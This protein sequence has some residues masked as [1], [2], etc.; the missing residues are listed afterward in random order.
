MKGAGTGKASMGM[1]V[2]TGLSPASGG[3]TDGAKEDS[4]G[5]VDGA[6]IEAGS[7][8]LDQPDGGGAALGPGRV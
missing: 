3:R 6:G 7:L 2:P 5:W 8:L 1:L 4:A